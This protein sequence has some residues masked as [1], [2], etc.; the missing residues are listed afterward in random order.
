MKVLLAG[1]GTAGHINPAL[2]I[3]RHIRERNPQADIKFVGTKEGLEYSLVT[4]E[5]YPLYYIDV[6]GFKRKFTAY[7]LGAL[8]RVFTSLSQVKKILKE[9]QPDIVIGTGGYV[10]W[11]VLFMASRMKIITAIHEQNALP[12][13]TTRLLA[14]RVDAVMISFEASRRYFQASRRIE[15]T[16]NP[17]REEIIFQ[18][19]DKCKQALGM[20][21]KPIVLS[22]GGSLG[23]R[24]MNETLISFIMQTCED[25]K[26]YHIH[27]TGERGYLWV[28][29]KLKEAGFEKEK[30]PQIQV[31]QYI[32]HMPQVLAAA[33]VVICRAGATT[34]S[35]IAAQGK[36][37]IL[38]P[39]PN[40][41]NDHQNYN[42]R[43]FY[44]I[45]AAEVIAEQ[46]LSGAL[47][48]KKVYE[49]L[50]CPAKRKEMEEKARSLAVLDSNVKIYEILKS[51][52]K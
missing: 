27:A 3:A 4:K 1:G 43:A 44:E 23:A 13:L 26:F 24:V 14:G 51:L 19:R 5:G 46:D 34:L 16:G 37:A 47:L 7:N 10:S 48:K 9:Y 42:A 50:D 31:L 49:L 32:Y 36:C 28:P 21:D 2:A 38:V 33:N 41:T 17:I 22:F 20:T 40:V 30:Y 39:S 52:K 29:A 18:K 12:G 6:R 45:G 11:P 35:E 8:H 15:L 25:N